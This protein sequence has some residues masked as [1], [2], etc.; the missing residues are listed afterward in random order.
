VQGRALYFRSG[1]HDGIE[2]RRRGKHARPADG[3][4]YIAQDRVLFL[5]RVFERLRPLR[6]F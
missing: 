6:E 3:Y 4:L 2:N 5:R 1:E